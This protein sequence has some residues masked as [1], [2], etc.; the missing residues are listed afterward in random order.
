MAPTP[1]VPHGQRLQRCEARVLMV[2]AEVRQVQGFWLLAGENGTLEPQMRNSDTETS[3]ETIATRKMKPAVKGVDLYA[4][5]HYNYDLS[6]VTDNLAPGLVPSSH[7]NEQGLT[8]VVKRIPQALCVSP[9]AMPS[10]GSSTAAL[11]L[12]LHPRPPL[13]GLG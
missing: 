12:P 4:E 6:R 8:Q 2:I 5:K 11:R 10:P 13:G 1:K 3:S 7:S 9:R